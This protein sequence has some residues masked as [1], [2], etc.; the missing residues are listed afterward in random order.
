LEEY[1]EG[2]MNSYVHKFPTRTVYPNLVLTRGLT[3]IDTLWN[4]YWSTTQ[5]V[6]VQLSGTIM[7][8]DR[9]RLPITWWNF[10]DAYPVKWVGPQFNASSDSQVAVE[11]IE[12]V[13]RGITKPFA[14]QALALSRTVLDEL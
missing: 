8:L 10:K 7:L 13:H 11:R 6:I 3:A 12:F 2:G 9:K 14:A 4:W 5:G 1:Q